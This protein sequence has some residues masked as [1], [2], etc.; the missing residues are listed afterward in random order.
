MDDTNWQRGCVS[1][2]WTTCSQFTDA[3]PT[4]NRC[5]N[6]TVRNSASGTFPLSAPPVGLEGVTFPTATFTIWTK[7]EP[8]V[9][10]V[11]LVPV[12]AGVKVTIKTFVRGLNGMG[13]PSLAT[14]RSVKD[15]TN[16]FSVF[17]PTPTGPDDPVP[18]AVDIRHFA[19]LIVAGGNWQP[20]FAPP[21]SMWYSEHFVVRADQPPK[22]TWRIVCK[23][24]D[25][26]SD[27]P[28]EGGDHDRSGNLD[29]YRH[30]HHEYNGYDDPAPTSWDQ[31]D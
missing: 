29:K 9:K 18:V 31:G 3:Y 6:P 23:Q 10:K 11:G 17:I 14:Y 22:L 2:G 19:E 24:G 13:V 16:M 12:V 4:E 28:D 15:D 27:D 7:T 8:F 30:N 21:P 25:K 5:V 1:G 26:A 20:G